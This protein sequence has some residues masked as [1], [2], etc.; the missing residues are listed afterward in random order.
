MMMMIYDDDDDDDDDRPPSSSTSTLLGGWQLKKEAI[1]LLQPTPSMKAS[2]RTAAACSVIV[3]GEP[4][5]LSLSF[6]YAHSLIYASLL[7]ACLSVCRYHHLLPNFS[8]PGRPKYHFDYS[9][10]SGKRLSNDEDIE[11]G[12]G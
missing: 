9:M 12:Q 8:A 5:S 10:E 11:L 2:A 3:P 1:P 4:C 6:I 7:S